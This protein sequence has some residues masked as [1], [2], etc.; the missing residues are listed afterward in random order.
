VQKGLL[1]QAL[2]VV[3]SGVDRLGGHALKMLPVGLVTPVLMLSAVKFLSFA[4]PRQ[5]ALFHHLVNDRREV[6]RHEDEQDQHAFCDEVAH[7]RR[8]DSVRNYDAASVAIGSVPVSVYTVPVE[9][10]SNEDGKSVGQQT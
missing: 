10:V 1:G 2:V 6:S 3:L 7:A 9:W 8:L 5:A 4:A